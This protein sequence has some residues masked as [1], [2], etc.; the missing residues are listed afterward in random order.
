MAHRRIIVQEI[1][2]LDGFVA[3]ASGGLDFFEVV[4]DYSEVN[5][6][7]LAIMET[8][9]T[10]LLG[11]K[12]YQLFVDFWPTAEDEPVADVVNS[13]PKIVFSSTLG[14]APWGRF[15]PARV[16]A[17]DPV[18]HVR[19]MQQESGGDVMVWG[20]ISLVQS[21]LA[22]GLVDELQLRVLPIMLSSGRRLISEDSGE[23]R[24]ALLQATP[25]SS[26]ILALRYAVGQS[27]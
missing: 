5:Q 10:L 12:T 25:F 27:A 21:L 22:A 13:T 26:G 20:S 14:G 11:A 1:V 18:E 6:E 3:D 24:M 19:R 2:S 15:D 17:G 8:V 7:N 16:V 23:H 4:S 9:D